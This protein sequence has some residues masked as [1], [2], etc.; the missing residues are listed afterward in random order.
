MVEQLVQSK[1]VLL[2]EMGSGKTSL[3]QRFVRGQYFENQVGAC[4]AALPCWVAMPPCRPASAASPSSAVACWVL[5]ADGRMLPKARRSAQAAAR[6]PA[7]ASCRAQHGRSAG[8]RGAFLCLRGARLAGHARRGSTSGVST[9]NPS[10]PPCPC[11]GPPGPPAGVHHR[12][13]VL[14]QDHPGEARQV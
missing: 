11:P 3:V 6:L 8:I 12:R 14:H 5:S 13:L 10:T 2:G 4:A 9:P 1:L 7:P